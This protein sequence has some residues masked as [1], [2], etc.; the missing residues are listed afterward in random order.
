[1]RLTN[2]EIRL[3]RHNG[4]LI[5]PTR[6]SDEFVSTIK[7]AVL[8]DIREEVEPVV[9]SQGRVVRISDLWS[10]G[11]VFREAIASDAILDPLESLLGANIE[12]LLNRHN[13]ATLRV[14]GDGSPYMH[15]D[16]LQWT[17]TIVT[18]I[19]YLEETNLE[20]GCTRLVPGTHLLP[21]VEEN[22]LQRDPNV[23]ASRLVDQA[24]AVPM[25]AGGLLA[26]DSMTYHTAGENRTDGTR[27]NLTLGYHSADELA[28]YEN[29]RRALLRGT[30]L[31]RGNDT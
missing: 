14:R 26:I 25:P 12:Y 13:H 9:R 23:N 8:R 16:V 3:F 30:R 6:F 28:G 18:V 5:L 17:R 27:M 29:P 19:V 11:G 15:R 20:N 31:Y 22:S 1:M 21:G 4:F 2:D 24:V 10:R 7:E